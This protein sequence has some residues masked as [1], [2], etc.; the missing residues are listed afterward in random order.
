MS[1]EQRARGSLDVAARLG[2]LLAMRY[3][4][5]VRAIE[6]GP[7]GWSAETYVV[8]ATDGGRCFV[9]VYEADRVPPNAPA[10]LSAVAEMRRRGFDRG[11]A[12]IASNE[13]ARYALLGRRTVV[14][15]EYIEGAQTADF[16]AAALGALIAQV[17]ELTPAITTP[18]AREAFDSPY[19]RELW[20]TL[21]RAREA[22]GDETALALRALAIETRNELE[23]HWLAFDEVRRR[24]LDASFDMVLTHGDAL[25]NVMTDVTGAIHLVDWDDLLLA[26][27]ERDLWC[28]DDRPAFLQAY[29][30]VRGDRPTSPLAT[31]FYVY[32]RYFSEWLG[33]ARAILDGDAAERRVEALALLRGPWMTSLRARIEASR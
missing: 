14:V 4:T 24:C 32:E 11:S 18:V 13:G 33:F 31:T 25:W 2:E 23:Q 17:H 9:K 10:G 8:T 30:A 15:F 1:N 28:F 19:A 26:P 6:P 7:R 12:P 3:G 20:T 27:P 22:S 21:D 5:T 16:D 29:H